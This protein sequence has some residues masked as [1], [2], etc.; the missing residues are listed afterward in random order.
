MKLLSAFHRVPYHM[1][2]GGHEAKLS[3]RTA[4]SALMRQTKPKTC[5]LLLIR[6]LLAAFPTFLLTL[7]YEDPW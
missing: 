5:I 3:T 4:P 6:A 2:T 1:V 7:K